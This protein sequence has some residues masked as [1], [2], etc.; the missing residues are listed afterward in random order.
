MTTPHRHHPSEPD[1]TPVSTARVIPLHRVTCS[2]DGATVIRY[3]R[4]RRHLHP[5]PP[6]QEAS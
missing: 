4:S 2:S 6:P 1:F 3:R 5:L